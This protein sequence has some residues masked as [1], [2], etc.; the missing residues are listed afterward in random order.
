MKKTL[1]EAEKIFKQAVA[2][3]GTDELALYERLI[4]YIGTDTSPDLKALSAKAH[5]NKGISLAQ[6]G[7]SEKLLL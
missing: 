2:E 5:L 1:Q 7:I 6:Q 4:K 3:S